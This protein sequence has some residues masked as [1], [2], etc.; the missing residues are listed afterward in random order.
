MI[1]L[2]GVPLID[3]VHMMSL[4]PARILHIDK[5]K[6]SL[7][8]GKDADI[9]IYDKDK[10]FTISVNNMHSD[11]DHTI[12]EGKKLHGYPVQTYLRGSL[13]YDNGD[14]V[15]TPGNGKYVKRSTSK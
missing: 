11:C 6:G 8:I 4:T 9:V 15:G 1:Y 5:E 14:F 7:E 12:W 13:V 10:D 3:A 2:A